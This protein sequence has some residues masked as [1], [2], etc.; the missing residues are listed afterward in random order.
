MIPLPV[1]FAV[2][3]PDN[4]TLADNLQF[5]IT[6]LIVVLFTL[7]SLALLLAVIGQIF[8]LR[9]RKRAKPAATA[10]APTD[11]PVPAPILAAIAAAVSSA[12]GDQRV[13]IHGIRTVDPRT[14]LAWS[15]E[16]RRS[17]YSSKKLR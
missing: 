12:L 16:G 1:I 10:P 13:V 3:L 11:E 6:G 9:D 2:S 14:S 5:Q 17:I 8:I 15:V 4:P 7:G